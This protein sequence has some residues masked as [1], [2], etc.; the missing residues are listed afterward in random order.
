MK[1]KILLT[2][3]EI[4]IELKTMSL[5]DEKELEKHRFESNLPFSLDT[6]EPYQ[7][8]QWVLIPKMK[9]TINN[10]GDLVHGFSVYPYF[11]DV[12]IDE[13]PKKLLDLLHSLDTLV[14]TIY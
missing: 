10:D 7:W 12:W 11:E 3:I 14:N 8:L 9:E 6:M 1:K 2:L 13:K 4:E 5:W